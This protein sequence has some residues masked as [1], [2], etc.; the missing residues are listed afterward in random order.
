M[1]QKFYIL[2]KLLLVICCITSSFFSHAVIRYVK[3]AATGTGDG[4]S[5]ANA[6]SNLQLMINN[7]GIGDQV[8]VKAGTYRP[9]RDINGSTSPADPRSK[10]FLLKSGVLIYGGFDGTETMLSERDIASNLTTLTGD[11]GTIGDHTDNAYHVTYANNVT[12]NTRLDGFRVTRGQADGSILSQDDIGSALYIFRGGT[13]L[14]IFYCTFFNNEGDRGGAIFVDAYTGSNG[15]CSPVISNCQIN[16]NHANY[17]AGIIMLASGNTSVVSPQISHCTFNGNSG[18]LVGA[19]I[20]ISVSNGAVSNAI[21]ND[22]EFKQNTCDEGAALYM[23]MSSASSDCSPVVSNCVFT[24]NSALGTGG[25]VSS[26]SYD[27]AI[28]T[29][30]FQNCVFSENSLSPMY[31]GAG[32]AVYLRG[33]NTSSFTNCTFFGNTYSASSNGGAAIG[34]NSFGGSDDPHPVVKNCIAWGNTSFLGLGNYTTNVTYSLIQ[35]GYAGAG[36]VSTNAYFVNAADPDGADNVWGTT[37]DGLHIMPISDALDNGTA[38]GAPATDIKGF[39]RPDGAGIDMGAY[40]GSFCPL[41]TR[42]YVDLGQSASATPNGTGWGTKAFKSLN[43]AMYLASISLCGIT[44]IWV[45]EGTYLPERDISWNAT[46]ADSRDKTFNLPSGVSIYGGFAGTETLLS[47]RNINTNITILDANIG[48][49]A[50][51]DNAYHVAYAN[52][53]SSASRLDGFTLKNGNANG[54]AGSDNKGGAIYNNR[55]GTNLTIANC[56]ITANYAT[57]GGAMY[58]NVAATGLTGSCSPTID[59]CI[60]QNNTAGL[61]AGIYFFTNNTGAIGTISCSPL[62]TNCRFSNTTSYQ[63]LFFENTNSTGASTGIPVITGCEFAGNTLPVLHFNI[64][65]SA[66]LNPVITN[67]VFSGNSTTGTIQFAEASGASLSPDFINC[68]FTN[69]NTISLLRF[70][71]NVDALFTNCSFSSN[72]SSDFIRFDAFNGAKPKPTFKNCI[73]WGYNNFLAGVGGSSVTVSTSIVQ[74]GYTGAVNADPLFVDQ[75]NPKGSDGIWATADDGLRVGYISYAIN[76]GNST[77]A[78]LTDIIGTTR[79]LTDIGAYENG[80]CLDGITKLYVDPSV[81]YNG[82]GNTWATAV[83]TLSDALYL[84]NN[85]SGISE[86]WVKAGTYKPER[87]MFGNT[88]PA[89]A[90]TKTFYF[91]LD[92]KVYGGFAGTETLLSQRNFNTNISSLSGAAVLAALSDNNYHV[93]NMGTGLLDGFTIKDGYASG[94]FTNAVGGGLYCN[95]PSN[96]AAI[97]RNCIFVNNYASTSG[98]AM[99]QMGRFG[100][101]GRIIENCTFSSNSSGISAGALFFDQGTI[102]GTYANSYVTNCVFAGN[103]SVSGGAISYEYGLVN[104][105]CVFSNNS[106]YNNTGSTTAGTFRIQGW[107]ASS[108]PPVFSNNIVWG[109]SSFFSGVVGS[110]LNATYNDIQVAFAGTGNINLDPLFVNP[111]PTPGGDY[112]LQSCSPVINAG[113]S[114]LVAPGVTTDMD[115][116]PRIILTD[117][118]MGAYEFQSEKQSFW[119][120]INFHWNDPQNWCG[121][122][123]P[124]AGTNVLI[125]NTVSIFPVIE[126]AREV[127]KIKLESGTSLTLTS[128][129]QITI[130][131]TYTNS[132][133][134]ITNNGTW[135]MAGSAASQTFPGTA[136]TVSAMNNLEINNASGISFDKSFSITGSLIP[137]AGNINVNNNI[138][139]TL[140]SSAT[141]TASV[142]VIQPA[143]SISYTGTGAFIAERFIN[144]GIGTGQHAKSWQFL[145]TPTTG[146]TIFQSW[147]EN[148][149]APAGFGTWI[150]GTGS[151][152]DVTTAAPSLKYFNEA[153]VNWTAVTNTGNA[154]VNK[155]GYMLFVRGDRTVTTYNGT[156]NNTIMRSKGQLFSPTNTAPS[157]AVTANKFQSFGNPYASRIEFNK[158]FTASTGINDVFY[159]WDPKLPGTY[160]LGGYQTITGAAFYIPTVGVPPTGNP[161]TDYYPA[162]VAAPYIESG[163]AV[164]V[165][166]NGTGGNVNFSESV[167]VSGS[168]LVNRPTGNNGIPKR[169]FLFTTLFTNTGE[170]ADGNIVAFE[171]GFGNNIN[172]HDAVK[173]MNPGENFGLT[174]NEIVLAVEARE[175]IAADDTIFYSMANLR[176]QGYQLRFAPINMQSLNLHPYLV[177]RYRNT[178][179]LLSLT[180]SSYVD[181][182]VNSDIA[183]AAVNRFFIV[184]KRVHKLPEAE[185]KYSKAE[186]ALND[187]KDQLISVYPNPVVNRE[188]NI[189]MK[190]L[191][192]GKYQYAL[193]NCNGQ[194]TASGVFDYT[195]HSRSIL[196]KPA[197]DLANGIYQL[198]LL[199]ETSQVAVVTVNM[200]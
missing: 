96:T 93:V 43:D 132:G 160:N 59:Q 150:T 29:A 147:Q 91:S 72:N 110:S 16:N 171:R 15:N 111:L 21:I 88:S 175:R 25:A 130:N 79:T 183:S 9:T 44:E 158:V 74:G 124:T 95:V 117:V 56:T 3:T 103:T 194:L 116:N 35:G 80:V 189:S 119:K 141:A 184:F 70:P 142:D 36:N 106:F 1:E 32:A 139:V 114:G 63:A 27:P 188:I 192:L 131:N 120:G 37:D 128:A 66:S 45:K 113:S 24:G 166:G 122:V 99:A 191:P 196:I 123:V 144:T 92:L 62:I 190:E 178:T 50:V 167:K 153:G 60:I 55:G 97:V 180:D 115:I 17:G 156:P 51:T 4:S 105:Y 112:R 187:E 199:H 83:K 179:T 129:G 127:N 76:N 49:A 19:G 14:K 30:S 136:A 11:I 173:L 81:S 174:R 135:I 52:N 165:K 12:A 102:G 87:D 10:T 163:Q 61:V 104:Q 107:G 146:Q 54:V 73:V 84:A 26:T 85:C 100:T 71:S 64:L 157:V 69:N 108:I 40:E 118:D 161:A 2:K 75:F 8:W 154:L 168:R 152:F 176:Q 31:I 57:T 200:Q 7:S 41:T 39:S 33:A 181:F 13:N 121:N 109:N 195:Q 77:G 197:V 67:C 138:A 5:W 126:D 18:G 155:L 34:M 82:K 94:T 137:T 140:K 47:Q 185:S 42:L 48:T 23:S 6:S 98:G 182:M 89:D 133:S 46:P 53:V 172:E 198:K 101:T 68:V 20:D 148:G 193:Y 38:T 159:V 143:A 22:C 151:G 177:D 78:P 125:P 28:I 90:R 134:N 186:N 164:F 169:Q 58:N 145:S 170:I 86:V 65:N 149:T 162:G